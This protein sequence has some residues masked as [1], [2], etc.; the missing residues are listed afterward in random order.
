MLSSAQMAEQMIAAR[1]QKKFEE[2]QSRPAP[3]RSVSH[4]IHA[5]DFALTPHTRA[6]ALALGDV[7]QPRHANDCPEA[8]GERGSSSEST[9]DCCER[10]LL[11]FVRKLCIHEPTTCVQKMEPLAVPTGRMS[12]KNQAQMM[13]RSKTAQKLSVANDLLMAN[14]KPAPVAAA[15]AVNEVPMPVHTQLTPAEVVVMS[16]APVVSAFFFSRSVSLPLI[17]FLPIHALSSILLD[18]CDVATPMQLCFFAAN[19]TGACLRRA[20]SVCVCAQK[21]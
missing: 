8:E 18:V 11:C 7:G 20:L 13:I 10:A 17:D 14:A 3:Q 9:T 4:A 5:G 2:M 12:S 15:P 6:C 21:N 1:K 19:K 16:V